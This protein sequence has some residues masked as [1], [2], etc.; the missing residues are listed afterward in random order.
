[1]TPR[2]GQRGARFT[3]RRRE[4]QK[5]KKRPPDPDPLPPFPGRQPLFEGLHHVGLLVSNL[6]RSLDFYM[7]TLGLPLCADRP[8]A[9]LPYRGAWLWVGREMVHLMEL[10]S[11]DPTEG[12]PS[13]GGRD[14]HFCV[15][16]KSVADLS[17]RLAAAGVPF[18][19]SASGRPAIFFRD[20]DANVLECA[21]MEPW[22]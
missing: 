19:A 10:P 15:G 5:K 12:R 21:E 3:P 4:R 18:T 8:D 2:K 13:H 7:G 9:R 11:P 22:R 1:M 14:R 16:V 20:P 6:E 17:A